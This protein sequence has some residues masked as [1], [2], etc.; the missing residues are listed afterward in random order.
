M[1]LRYSI[2]SFL[3][4]EKFKESVEN[5]FDGSQVRKSQTLLAGRDAI[6]TG[7]GRAGNSLRPEA[8]LQVKPRRFF[9][10]K[11]L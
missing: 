9:I 10:G 5:F 3:S 1:Y 2:P 8:R 6:L 7:T 4:R 11:H